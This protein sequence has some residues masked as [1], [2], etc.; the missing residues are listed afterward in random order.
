MMMKKERLPKTGDHFVFP[1]ESN[2]SSS[3]L[4]CRIAP[5]DFLACKE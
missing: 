5:E 3:L 4:H 2:S 1:F